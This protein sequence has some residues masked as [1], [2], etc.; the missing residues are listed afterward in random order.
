MAGRTGSITADEVIDLF[1]SLDEPYRKHAVFLMH[2]QT[3]TA[4]RKLQD[5]DGHYL[6]KDALADGQSSSLLGCPVFTS[7]YMPQMG[8]GTKP[9]LLGDMS[10]H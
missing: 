1:Y 7:P 4:L 8:T 10:Y 9:I 6:W 2:D 5:A 3:A